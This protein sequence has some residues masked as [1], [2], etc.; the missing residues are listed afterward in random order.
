MGVIG[1]WKL[2]GSGEIIDPRKLDGKCL[3]VD[4]SIWLHKSVHGYR[5]VLL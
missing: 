5:K 4:L 2:I 3:A 1:L